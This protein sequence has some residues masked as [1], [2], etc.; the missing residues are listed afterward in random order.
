MVLVEGTM[1]PERGRLLR[2]CA[3]LKP[4]FCTECLVIERS[5]VLPREDSSI[6]GPAIA[7]EWMA[8]RS[9]MWLLLGEK[10]FAV[11]SAACVMKA[12]WGQAAHLS[13]FIELPGQGED[14]EWFKS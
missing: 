2:G 1:V 5:C 9:A 6:T 7:G 8:F 3:S 10:A 14:L 4:Y 11:C 12:P 13:Q